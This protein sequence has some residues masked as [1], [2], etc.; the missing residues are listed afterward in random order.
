MEQN[1]LGINMSAVSAT[2]GAGVGF[3]VLEEIISGMDMPWLSNKTFLNYQNSLSE[4]W[5]QEIETEIEEN[6]REASK[7]AVQRG[8][9]DED[10]MPL[11][12]VVADGTWGKRSLS[13]HFNSLSGAA[14]VIDYHTKKLLHIGI[15]NKYCLICSRAARNINASETMVPK[16]VLVA[17]NPP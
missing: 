11:L 6:V 15:L 1:Q 16:R 5:N 2:N 10:G 14:A 13:R 17:W 3:S 8:D 12:T 7:N 9:V 4:L